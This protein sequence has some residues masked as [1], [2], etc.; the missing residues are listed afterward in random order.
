MAVTQKESLKKAESNKENEKSNQEPKKAP[1]ELE[2]GANI[3][4]KR[5]DGSWHAANVVHRRANPDNDGETE[6]YV[7]YEGFDRRLDEWIKWDR[8]KKQD[9]PNEPAA[10]I[11]NESDSLGKPKFDMKRTFL[12]KKLGIKWKLNEDTTTK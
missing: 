11:P 2:I 7:H 5:A 1:N 8:I 9:D 3:T 10:P 6:Y 4:A 12:S